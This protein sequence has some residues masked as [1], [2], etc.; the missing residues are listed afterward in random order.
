[1][2]FDNVLN[3]IKSAVVSIANDEDG[4]EQKKPI[5]ISKRVVDN[6]GKKKTRIKEK[7][8]VIRKTEDLPKYSSVISGKDAKILVP[9][10]KQS[11][12]SVLLLEKDGND[13][14]IVCSEQT[15]DL[16]IDNNFLNISGQC[17]ELGFRIKRSY[18][19]KDVIEIITEK[20][21]S[22]SSVVSEEE[23]GPVH[24][25]LRQIFR[26]AKKIGTSDIHIEVRKGD[27]NVY[28]R[29]DG[30]KIHYQQI[31]ENI[32]RTIARV[33]YSSLAKDKDVTFNERKPQDAKID[34]TLDGENISIRLA[35]IPASPGFDMVLRIL[36]AEAKE[37]EYKSLL[38]LGY[39]EE[40]VMLLEI[41]N[42]IPV[43]VIVLSGV[44]GSGKTTTLTTMINNKMVENENK[45][46]AI[47]IED[48][49]EVIMKN[50]T[51]V[52]VVRRVGQQSSDAFAEAMRAT[53]RCD[54]DILMPGEIRDKTTGSLLVSAVQSGHQVYTTVHAPSGIGS[55]DRMR[56]I[57]IRS[58]ILGSHDFISALVNQSLI[59]INCPHCAITVDEFLEGAKKTKSTNKREVML[60]LLKRVKNASN[61]QD[62]YSIDSV[63]F[64]S[65]NGCKH[66]DG[67]G[68]THREVIAE[69]IIPDPQMKKY[70][71]E[72]DDA[73]ALRYYKE[74]GGKLIIDHGLDKLFAGRIDPIS[75][76]RKVGRID[77]SEHTL[78]S[79]LEKIRNEI[80]NKVKANETSEINNNDVSD[81]KLD[82]KS[83]LKIKSELK[84]SNEKI[85]DF[86]PSK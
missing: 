38:E 45:L 40:H 10:D 41:A 39:S 17:K 26:A 47:T 19:T 33:A 7:I 27:A 71:K 34:M 78:G 20:E 30:D 49:P 15:I 76:E 58:A 31:K 2:L 48:P 70:F 74:S 25:R 65:K 22:L 24:D 4:N 21:D 36:P 56:E 53:L 60:A 12:Y 16:P 64:R 83:S 32:A 66:C 63:R 80:K 42:A 9:E 86:N 44:T 46:K 8:K 11:L 6:K 81:N 28:I 51:Q 62:N 72:E 54:P 59:P 55:I 13:V 75:L 3:S 29:V 43:G 23:K 79:V 52:P 67:R 84:D 37:Q 77:M 68:I 85:V 5:R 73:S 14:L 82:L 1:M 50:V 18:A 69:V 61:S 35:T 57:G